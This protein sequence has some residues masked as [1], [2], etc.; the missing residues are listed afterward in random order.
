MFL[1]TTLTS[2]PSEFLKAVILLFVTV[3]FGCTNLIKS[4]TPIL[5][6]KSTSSSSAL[7]ALNLISGP[8]I[9]CPWFIILSICILLGTNSSKGEATGIIVGFTI[10]TTPWFN[11]LSISIFE[12]GGA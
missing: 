10:S 1:G 4:P 12:F 9:V 11:S 7:R 2:V 6:V 3:P 8:L 5:W